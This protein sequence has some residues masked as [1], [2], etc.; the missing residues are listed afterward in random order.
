MPIVVLLFSGERRR[1][2]LTFEY[3][4]GDGLP[5]LKFAAR[6]LPNKSRDTELCFESIELSSRSGGPKVNATSWDEAAHMMRSRLGCVC[7]VREIF[8]KNARDAR[9]PQK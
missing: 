3:D 6:Q 1:F 7:G 9:Y 5:S 4:P 2:P 8:E